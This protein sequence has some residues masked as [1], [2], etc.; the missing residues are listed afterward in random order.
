MPKPL[1]GQVVVTTRP[2]AQSADLRDRLEALGATVV[3]APAV[4]IEP[5][6]DLRRVDEALQNLRRYDWLILTSV[7]GVNAVADRLKQLGLD[8]KALEAARLAAIGPVTADRLRELSLEP[9]VVPEEFVAESLADALGRQDMRGKRCLL[10]R[11]DI[12]RPA[13]PEALSSM[14]AVCDD[15]PI[16]RT[17]APKSLPADV[18]AQVRAG[19]VDWVTFTS[20][21]TFRNFERLLASEATTILRSVQ[22]ASIG[23]ITSKTIRDAGYE[24]TA[25]AKEYT[26]AGLVDAIRDHADRSGG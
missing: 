9:A 6:E 25:E 21:S 14:G 24:P 12:A 13:L 7:N 17:A 19:R 3:S 16:Y 26:I 10:L 4:V 23:P 8:A 5:V 11:S 20:S 15:I 2:A 18:I 1:K 22:I